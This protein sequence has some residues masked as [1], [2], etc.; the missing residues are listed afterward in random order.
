MQTYTPK[1]LT[2]WTLPD[3]Y[4]GPKW[5]KYYSSGFGHHRDS[6]CLSESNFYSCLKALGGESSTVIVVRE[7]NWAVGWVEW[8]AI[9]E[10]DAKALEIADSL[11]KE[12]QDYPVIDEADWS[13]REEEAAT[14][15]WSKC[16]DAKD[17]L[18]YI[19]ANR[20]QFEFRS[21]GD[22]R[23]QIKGEYFGGYASELLS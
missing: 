8:I 16:F 9:H 22:I 10:G 23:A 5:T 7:C 21:F 13:E 19:R 4:F 1:L 2:R 15:L 14:H 3:S 20:D 12:C 17:R 6:D 11:V 18:E